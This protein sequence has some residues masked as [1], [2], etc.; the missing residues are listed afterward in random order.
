MAADA[1]E[2][3][4]TQLTLDDYCKALN[5]PIGE[6]GLTPYQILGYLAGLRGPDSAGQ[7][8]ELSLEGMAFWSAADFRAK[9]AVVEELQEVLGSTGTPALH[10]YWGS[11]LTV[12]GPEDELRIIRALESAS[13][14][15]VDLRRSDTE[16]AQLLGTSPSESC[17][18]SERLV[19]TGQRLLEAPDLRGVEIES[20]EWF[21]CHAQILDNLRS[22]ALLLSLPVST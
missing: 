10:P 16:L 13:Q 6:S 2:R 9:R 7:L 5:N 17:A 12:C 1:D 3:R 18:E 11:Q 8:A 4:T 22:G 15:L 19:R 20:Q 21:S 14:A